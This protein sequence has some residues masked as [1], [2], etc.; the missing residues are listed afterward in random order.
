M[1][2]TL[3]YLA[4]T[5]ILIFTLAA[6]SKDKEP[7][8]Q[9]VL[10]EKLDGTWFLHKQ[11]TVIYDSLDQLISKTETVANSKHFEYNFTPPS[12]YREKIVD[13]ERTGTYKVSQD[14]LIIT[15]PE[16]PT[17]TVT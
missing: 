17:S 16:T 9:P 15:I 8:P 1:K 10:P 3:T 13:K 7:D 12:G 11:T 2:K 5:L 4:C 6:C 14:S